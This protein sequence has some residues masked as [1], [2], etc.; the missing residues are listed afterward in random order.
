MME[1]GF[2]P[3]KVHVWLLLTITINYHAITRNSVIFTLKR[4]ISFG[5]VLLLRMRELHF[6]YLLRG[7]DCDKEY[8]VQRHWEFWTFFGRQNPNVYLKKKIMARWNLTRSK[9][10]NIFWFFWPSSFA[11]H[12]YCTVPVRNASFRRKVRITHK[13]LV[14][15]YPDDV[16]W[17]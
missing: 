3:Q 7:R 14:I 6:G 11:P 17:P 15:G 1:F 13:F 2:K 9:R 12:N 10:Q 8:F 16:I 4:K 5:P